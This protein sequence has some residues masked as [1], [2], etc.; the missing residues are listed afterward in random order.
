[1]FEEYQKKLVTRAVKVAGEFE[2]VTLEG[3]LTCK[4]GYLA[5]DTEG[6]PYPIDREIFEKTYVKVPKGKYPWVADNYIDET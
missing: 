1:M 6:N 3:T 2:T 4:D 5:L